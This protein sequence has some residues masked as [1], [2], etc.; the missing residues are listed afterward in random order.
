M[1]LSWIT[2]YQ[3][4]RKP[5][6]P[7]AKFFVGW[8]WYHGIVDY[9]T[10]V[11]VVVDLESPHRV[12]TAKNEEKCV[13]KDV[14]MDT[15]QKLVWLAPSSQ[16]SAKRFHFNPLPVIPIGCRSTSHTYS[17]QKYVPPLTF[18]CSPKIIFPPRPE[19]EPS[20]SS[21]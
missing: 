1:L 18:S 3:R 19:W 20:S 17:P 12:R 4:S 6:D 13:S 16:R 7:E 14:S 10:T 8:E 21:L 9:C 2:H 5:I 15:G 11:R